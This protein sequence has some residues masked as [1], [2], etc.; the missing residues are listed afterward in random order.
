MVAVG[1]T[2]VRTVEAAAQ[3]GTL[4]DWQGSTNLF[5]KPGF[6]FNVTDQLLTNFHLP[7]STLMVLV[8]AI[9]GYDLTMEAYRQAVAEKYRFYSYG[10]AMLIL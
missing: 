6:D 8:A 3:Q 1:T 10:D 4:A 2:C 9:A 5:I 7:G